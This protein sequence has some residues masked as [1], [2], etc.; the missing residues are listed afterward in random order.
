MDLSGSQQEPISMRKGLTKPRKERSEKKEGR[1]SGIKRQKGKFERE[2]LIHISWR[3][4]P[5]NFEQQST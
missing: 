5:V 1:K 4:H 2:E 3:R